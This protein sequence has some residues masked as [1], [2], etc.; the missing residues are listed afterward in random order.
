MLNFNSLPIK[1]LK[2]NMAVRNKISKF[3]LFVI[4]IL[5]FM[6]SCITAIIY[7]I[8]QNIIKLLINMLA[9]NRQ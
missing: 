5:L 4:P 1:N 7:F 8:N 2:L 9:S 3:L 6:N